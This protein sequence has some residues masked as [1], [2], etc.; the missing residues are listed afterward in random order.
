MPFVATVFAILFLVLV[1]LFALGWLIPLIAGLV[2]R[3]KGKSCTALIVLGSVWGG[4]AIIGV[5]LVALGVYFY[6][7]SIGRWETKDFDLA[8]YDGPTATISVPAEGEIEMNASL[9]DGESYRFATDNGKFTVPAQ[10]LGIYSYSIAKRDSNEGLWTLTWWFG[11]GDDECKLD[12]T[13]GQSVNFGKGPPVTV[14]VR[15]KEKADGTQNI[16]ME[17]VDSEG[18][19][20]SLSAPKNP[21]IQIRDGSGAVVWSHKMEYG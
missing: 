5:G 6:V 3:K 11:W 15:R 19:K 8:E 17:T 2:R 4:L 9:E 10:E 21:V 12:L 7:S 14:K 13:A 1:S 18:D 16:D 20:V